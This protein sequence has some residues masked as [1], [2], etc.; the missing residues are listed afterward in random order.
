LDVA[1]TVASLVPSIGGPVAS[2]LSGISGGRKE[3]RILEV[4]QGVSDD[5]RDFHSD[6]AEKY[7]KTEDFEE[8][9]ENTLRRAAQERTEEKR[10][11]YRNILTKA[12]KNPGGDCGEQ[13]RFLKTLEEISPDHV[14]ILRASKQLPEPEL[15]IWVPNAN[16][17]QAPAR[18]HRRPHRPARERT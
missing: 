11:L 9:L 5:L 16:S 6:V 15:G 7:V 13:L 2:I 4:I 8:L 1:A 10:R 17:S 3:Q 12:I 18:S 14:L